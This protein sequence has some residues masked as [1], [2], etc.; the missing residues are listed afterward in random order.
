MVDAPS[1][2]AK[3]VL[4]VNRKEFVA[5]LK[6]ARKVGAFDGQ[7]TKLTYD[8]GELCVAAEGHSFR[9]PADGTW[10][11]E[12]IVDASFLR[13]LAKSPLIG[14]DKMEIATDRTRLR[15]DFVSTNCEWNA[16]EYPRIELPLGASLVDVLRLPLR[17]SK[18][19]IERSELTGKLEAA[20]RERDELVCKAR[21]LLGRANEYVRK[22]GDMLAPLG[23]SGL[24]PVET[25]AAKLLEPLDEILYERTAALRIESS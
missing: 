10:P 14:G 2:E 22:A 23:F 11:G 25:D 21:E 17:Y 16:L 9:V 6:T 3:A 19:D 18:A 20:Q 24:P 7:A 15:I 5:R 13:R 1:Q 4:W 12:V 8:S